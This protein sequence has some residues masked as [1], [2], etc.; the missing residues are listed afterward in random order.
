MKEFLKQ[1]SDLVERFERN[2]EAYRSPAYNETQLRREFIDPFFEALGWD[3]ANKAGYAEQYKDVIHEDAIKIAGA[4]K[5]PDYCFRIGGVRKFFLETKKPSIDIKG[6]SS[7]A[8]QLKRYAWSAKLPISILTDFEE[9]AIY[10]CRLRP[11]PSDKPSIGRVRFYTYNQYIDSF[12]E[13]YDLLSKESVLKGSFDKFA[14]SERQ[15]RGTAEVDSEFLKEI[16]SWREA[17]AKDIAL[18]NPRLTVPE[19]NFAVQ[20]TI[21]RIIFLRMCEDRGIEHYGQIQNL[22]NGTNTYRRLREIFYHADDKY[23]SG[24]FDFKTDRLTPELK[25]D[26]KPLKDIFKNLY[27]PESPY[28]FSVLG[29][30][31]LGHVYE[32]F[33]GKVIRLTEGHRAKVEEKPEVRKA[34][35]V[36]YTPTYIVDYIVKNTVGKIVGTGL[37]ARPEEGSHREVPLQHKLTPKQISKICILDPAC[38]S[39]SFLLGAYQYLLDYH[40]DWYQKDS[41]PKHTKEIYQGRGGQW[42]LTIQEKKRILLNNI[43]GV[44]IDPQAVEVTKLSLLLKVM[45][46]EN[47]DTLERQMKLF[48][49]RALPD[50]GSNIKCGNSLIGP[51]FYQGKQMNLLGNEEIYRINAFDWEKEFPDIMKR[52]GFDAVIGNP[53][54]IGIQTMKEWAPSEVEIYKDLYTS[55]SRGNYDIYVVFVE[56]GLSLLNKSGRL[57]FILPH[58]FFNAQY[59]E[60]LRALLSKGKNLTE[61]VH[62]GD[63][64]VFAGATNYTCLLFLVKAGSKQCDFVKVDELTAWRLNGEATEGKI[65]ATK[66]TS[67]EWNFTVGKAAD[68]FEKLNKVP[69]KLGDIAGRIFQGLVTGADPVFILSD[70]SK[71]KYLSEATQ[72]LHRIESDLMHPLCKGSL[73]IRRYHV[74]ELTKSILFP[75]KYVEGKAELL[76]AKELGESYPNAWEYL[77]INRTAL[78]SRERGKWKHNRWYAFGRSQNLNEMEQKKILT[79]SIAKSASFTLD[80]RDLYYFVGSGGGGGGGYGIT[81]KSDEQMAY[82][83]FLGLLNSNL[84]DTFLKSFSTTFSGGYFAYNRQYIEQ[85]PIRTINFSDPADEARHDKMLDLVEQMLTLH[86]QLAAAKTPDDKTRLQRQID[87]TDQQIDN[88]VYEL[89][90]LTENEIK[91]VEGVQFGQ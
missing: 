90:G 25:V 74:S 80:S 85:L 49:E 53:P 32:Q 14:E 9:T 11:K 17:L 23:N 40:R 72:Q 78:E 73:N 57:G 69:V 63:K 81:L 89:Y 65:P 60:P 2:I 38:G 20:L 59:G 29:A 4:T 10:D 6:Q 84:L 44:D 42:Y 48:K 3:V 26:D 41:T 88:L 16:E 22:L 28:E 31:I 76:T 7:P 61:V 68:L 45:E 30:D 39:G 75:Y 24:L 37:S 21:D 18:K 12:E 82:E 56:R 36:Y 33:L 67:S 47:Q 19:L 13:I 54:Y 70:H 66:I 71:G 50:L 27:Y 64:Q 79:P 86:E 34:G 15:K 52:G 5:A 35:G 51:D 91:I 8:Y 1:I 46:G 43:Y 58:K 83:Y 87:A 77:K 62:F 55:A